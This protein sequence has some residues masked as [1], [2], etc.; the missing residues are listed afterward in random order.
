[1]RS[2]TSDQRKSE[3]PETKTHSRVAEA[4]APSDSNKG[5]E[6]ARARAARAR[7]SPA[8]TPYPK[9]AVARCSATVA[10]IS[11]KPLCMTFFWAVMVV[12]ARTACASKES[13]DSKASSM[14]D[15]GSATAAMRSFSKQTTR[16]AC[17]RSASNP[18]RAC[19]LRRRPSN[20]K[21][22]VAKTATWA[23]ICRAASAMHGAAPEPVPPPSPTKRITSEAP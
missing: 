19:S 10:A 16:L 9:S 4:S 14:P 6:K 21:G 20:E 11:S 8:A 12:T 3:P 2:C 23:P 18:S 1:M 5:F 15:A 13:T 22:S 7:S 17:R